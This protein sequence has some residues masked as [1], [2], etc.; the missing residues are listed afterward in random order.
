V[1]AK[2]SSGEKIIASDAGGDPLRDSHGH[3]IVRHDL[4]N[5]DG[6]TGDGIAEAFVEFAKKENLSFF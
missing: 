2:D 1:P 6:L 4:F 3:D 5:V